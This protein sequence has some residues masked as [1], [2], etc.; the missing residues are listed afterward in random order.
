MNEEKRIMLRNAFSA[1][2]QLD[3]SKVQSI[4][5]ELVEYD[6]VTNKLAL[7]V[8]YSQENKEN[9]KEYHIHTG[10]NKASELN[11]AINGKEI[12]GRILAKSGDARI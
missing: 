1:F 7:E 3:L 12:A 8:V 4:N 5:L 10:R 9:D 11:I 2:E 6:D